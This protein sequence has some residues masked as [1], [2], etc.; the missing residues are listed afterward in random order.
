MWQIGCLLAK[1]DPK[2]L[3]QRWR[4]SQLCA[5]SSLCTK[6]MLNVSNSKDF[7]EGRM[8]SLKEIVSEVRGR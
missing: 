7:K 5:S 2:Q 4:V 3:L 8:K 6:M 1:Y